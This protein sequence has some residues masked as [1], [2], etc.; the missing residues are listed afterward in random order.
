MCKLVLFVFVRYPSS[1]KKLYFPANVLYNKK[2]TTEKERA[3][4]KTELY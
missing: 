3:E 4:K 2:K 1:H